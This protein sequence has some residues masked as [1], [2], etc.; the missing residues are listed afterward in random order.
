MSINLDD[1]LLKGSIAGIGTAYR[2]RKLSVVEAAHWFEQ[3]IDALNGRG[4]ALNA[5]RQVSTRIAEDAKRLDAELTSGRDRGPLHGIPVALKD[6]ILTNDGMKASAGAA[7]LADFIPKRDATLVR[8][9]RDAGAIVFAKAN[10]TEF[11][12]FVSDV[13]PSEFS[14]AGGIVRNPH[15]IRYDRGQGSSVG[16]AAVVAAG[17]CPVAIGSETQN[18]IQTPA[19]FTSVVGF[20]PTVGLV[21]RH[22]VVPLVTSQDSPGPLARN[23]ADA[24][25]VAAIIAG[26]D[27][28]DTA[29]LNVRRTRS[30]VGGGSIGGLRIG[31][32]RRT[33]ADRADLAE[34]MPLFEAMLSKLS[35]AGAIIVDPCDL[36]TAEQ[37]QEARSCVFRAEFKSA[38]GAFLEAQ[39]GPCGMHSMADIIAWNEK[40]PEAIPFGQ[41]LLIA[42]D[43]TGGVDDPAY[44]TDRARDIALSLTGGI[45][46]ALAA[47]DVDL[48]IVP[49]G[50]AAKATGK[51]GTPVVAL[52]VGVAP[53]GI[54]FGVTLLAGAG[55]D[56]RLLALAA[57][58]EQ[59]IG[60]R[61]IPVL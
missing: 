51:A 47:N 26:P 61:L 5:V 9:L 16:P 38:L 34:V 20:K 12:D 13:M 42:A 33:I 11:A 45:A 29:S 37:L 32:P 25:L 36:P 46:A 50:A 1:L 49:M 6:N 19:S 57:V 31:V 3:R 44:G 41:S 4:P 53:S 18:S 52:P 35:K 59:T 10:L 2:S 60:E 43:A 28:Y 58:I 15:G 7:A 22:G 23:V 8:R 24:R 39:G 55:A 54:P 17:L 30:F 21:S 40:H 27:V 14:G 48:L 56:F